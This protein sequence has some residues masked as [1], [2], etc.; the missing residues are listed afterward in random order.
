MAHQPFSFITYIIAS[1]RTSTNCTHYP[2][3]GTPLYNYQVGHFYQYE[4]TY[5][6][7]LGF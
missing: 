1:A 7:V 6:C 5:P 2:Q 4:V 3:E